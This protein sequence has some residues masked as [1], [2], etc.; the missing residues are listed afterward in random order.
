[1]KNRT[2]PRAIGSRLP[3][4]SNRSSRTTVSDS[5]RTANPDRSSRMS[6]EHSF[7]RPSVR[8]SDFEPVADAAM[9]GSVSSTCGGGAPSEH[10]VTTSA[11]TAHRRQS[12]DISAP[13]FR[14]A[15]L[16]GSLRFLGRCLF[17]LRLHGAR[18]L[19][20]LRRRRLLGGG[21]RG[22]PSPAPHPRGGRG[23]GGGGAAG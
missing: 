13:L 9:T 22:S 8:Q 16:R 14:A 2:S 15:R 1:M 5:L 23:R 11:T 7:Q 18:W 4:I 10:P 17:G 3:A 21:G 19:C 20:L 6:A 12:R